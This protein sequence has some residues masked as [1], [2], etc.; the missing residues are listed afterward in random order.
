[1]KKMSLKATLSLGFGTAIGAG[2][3]TMT[4]FGTILTGKG[5]FLAFIIAAI[6][7]CISFAPTI[8][9]GTVAPRFGGTYTYV[10]ELFHPSLG[11]FFL[12]I[13]T[14]AKI[15][16]AM[17]SVSFANYL[18]SGVLGITDIAP[19]FVNSVALLVLTLLYLANVTGLDNTVK[20][21]NI[22]IITLI[23]TIV[24]FI[25][26]G[27]PRCDFTNFLQVD[28]LFPNGIEGFIA[29]SVLL[30]FG[31]L[32]GIGVVDY[33]ANVENAERNV[34]RA[35]FII[36]GGLVIIT[37]LFGIVSSAIIPVSNPSTHLFEVAIVIG[38]AVYGKIF[39]IGAVLL[40]LATTINGNFPWFSKVMIKG[41]QDG[42]LPAWMGKENKFGAHYILHTI[43]YGLCAL[44]IIFN[45]PIMLLGSIATGLTLLTAVIPNFALIFASKKYS[46]EWNSSKFKHRKTTFIM[47]VTL[48]SNAVLVFAIYNLAKGWSIEIL[49]GVGI[50]IALAL[51]YATI[52][53]KKVSK[54][55]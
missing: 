45:L 53:G 42:Y 44:I 54:N 52:Q 23:I 34:P 39:V 7:V 3:V 51:V 1:M 40:A 31:V 10:K 46:Q 27:L 8:I 33:G 36:T 4:A 47:G 28:T 29:A 11:V 26:L 17:F 15:G 30:I 43:L 35:I 13:F 2:L 37:V 20:V 50:V 24:S 38:G 19:I 5:V 16:V 12:M 55:A 14:I 49:T 18:L 48:T 21:Q 9:L 22:M 32:G 6:F 25:V 41:V